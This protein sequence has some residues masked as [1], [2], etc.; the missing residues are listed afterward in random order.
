M[1]EAA[2]SP[3]DSGTAVRAE[4]AAWLEAMWN[5]DLPLIEWR[6]RLLAARW[7]SPSWPTEWHGRDLP[8][9]ADEVVAEEI[10]RVGAVGVPLG[11]GMGLA[12]P[13]VLAHGSDHVKQLLLGRIL[14]GEDSWC[15]LF[16]EP[17]SGSDL[18]GLTTTAR[19]DGDEWVVNG[20]KLWSTSAHHAERGL[21]LARTD[22]N[23]P[24]HRGI[25]CFALPMH[26]HGVEA[27]P[28]RQ[29]NGHSSFNE[30]FL[31][32]ARIPVDDVIGAPGQ[33]WRVALTTLSH[34]RRYA[35]ARPAK[36]DPTDGKTV[37]EAAAEAEEYLRTYEWYPQRAGRA[38]LVIEVARNVDRADDPVVRQR[39]AA[40]VAMQRTQQWTARRAQTMR[41]LG[42]QPGAE[43]SIGK[44]GASHVARMAA[45]VHSLLAGA[46]AMLVGPDA[47]LRGIIGEILI[48]VPAQSIAG[49]T[50][51]IQR[52]IL[53]EQML[54]LPREPSTDRDVPFRE[55]RGR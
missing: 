29:M 41:A 15:Q 22:W 47:M 32:D 42:R 35:T 50:D 36:P 14:T 28:L 31:T 3:A 27:R 17:G 7:A 24:K 49:G 9:W 23:V 12:A 55:I 5:P 46:E 48:S 52:N 30:V 53:G 8:S 54:G 45:E 4:V 1:R 40:L 34:E 19:L 16:S 33:G 18:A 43:G 21:L 51:E 39:I 20:Q 13:T 44:L 26:Q 25:T 2:E 6:H 10:G 37:A 11:V 38:D